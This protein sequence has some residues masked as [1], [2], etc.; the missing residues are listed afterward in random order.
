MPLMHWDTSFYNFVPRSYRTQELWTRSQ[1]GIVHGP[2]AT[3]EKQPGTGGETDPKT[4]PLLF[5]VVSSVGEDLALPSRGA[6]EI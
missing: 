3:G 1:Q 2:A 5:V 6:S 4:R